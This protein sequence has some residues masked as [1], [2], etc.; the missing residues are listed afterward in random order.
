MKRLH[1]IDVAKGICILAVI[2]GHMGNSTINNIVF[3]FHLTVFFI[4]SGYTMKENKI[5]KEYLSQKFKRLM[6]P[7]FIT[8]L[9][10]TIMDIINLILIKHNYT[11]FSISSVIKTDMLRTFFASGSITNFGTINLNGRIGAIWF[12]PALFFG[13]IISKVIIQKEEKYSKKFAISGII[14]IIAIILSKFIWLPFSIQSAMLACPFII[15]G[16]FLKEKEL[17]DKIKVKETIILLLIFV[18]GCIINKGGI[19]F[20]SASVRDLIITPI[21]AISA[22]L[23]VIK[24]AQLLEKVEILQ[25]IGRNSLYI[26]C[27]H[28]F[29]LETAGAYIRKIYEMVGIEPK[30]YI[31]FIIHVIICLAVTGLINLLK[32]IPKKENMQIQSK[33]NKTIDVLRAICI[34]LMMIGHVNV[35]AGFRRFIYSFHMTAFILLSGYLYKDSNE[36]VL[37]RIW[38]EIK[39]LIIPVSIYSI[40]FVL[41]KNKGIITE[42]KTLIFG[43]SFSKNILKGID[44]IGP[45]YFVLLLF[46]VK[47]IYILVNKLISVIKEKTGATIHNIYIYIMYGCWDNVRKKRILVTMEH[48]FSII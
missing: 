40:L 7:Y 43:M 25:Y 45:F 10:I 15:F 39:R 12:F 13:L 1:W 8:C 37:K 23:F 14:A 4:L 33:R 27:T 11:V 42:I 16:K 19:Y 41:V 48:R 31:T 3:P 26:L 6:I 44:S 34:I 9:C 47:I 30:F 46:I 24:I 35:D 36:G 28:L 20:V 17:I 22:S 2:I 21:V 5:D 18:L 32:K 38:K 29:L